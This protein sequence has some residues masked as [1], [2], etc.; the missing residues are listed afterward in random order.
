MSVAKVIPIQQRRGSLRVGRRR[1]LRERRRGYTVS[2]RWKTF[3]SMDR[4]YV[5]L[6]G[7]VGGAAA[8]TL[9]T[10]LLLR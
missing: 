10:A 4:L 3:R 2:R 8:G 1:M 9:I 6:A 7:L 5:L